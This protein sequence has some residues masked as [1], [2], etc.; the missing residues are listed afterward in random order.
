M[1]LNIAWIGCGRHATQMLLPQLSRVGLSIRALCDQN[2][3]ALKRT[4][5]HYGVRDTFLNW[6][7]MLE[8]KG[9]DAVCMAVGP[10][11]HHRIALQALRRDLPVFMEKPPALNHTD[12]QEIVSLAKK[13]RL[14]VHV[15]FMKRYSS[16][17]KIA[18]NILSKEAFGR[19]L[20]VQ[21]TYMTAP[22]YF[23]GEVD[24]SGFYLHHCVH[25][26]DLL[27]WLVSSAFADFGV[28]KSEPAPGKLLFHLNFEC[29]NGVIGTIVMG[30]VQSRGTP[31]EAIIIM[32][33]H[34]RIEINNVIDVSWFRDPPFKVDDNSASLS[35]TVDTLTWTPNFTV[36]A[37]E[38]HK[39]YVA[40]LEDVARGFRGEPTA[41]PTIEDASEAMFWLEKMIEELR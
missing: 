6:E 7:E 11:A 15:G 1:T 16:G 13:K 20:G 17:N 38:D 36:A 25:Y 35:E 31:M 12:A 33:D 19:I 23:E 27:P 26:M 14:A 29:K 22:T 39:G 8:L 10:E 40:L 9:L 32:G 2:P 30:T 28:R 24:Y 3:E 34:Q 21:A 37:N 4:A 41:A 18:R 5:S